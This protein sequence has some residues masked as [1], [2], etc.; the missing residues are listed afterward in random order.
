[1]S[2]LARQDRFTTAETAQ[3][4]NTKKTEEQN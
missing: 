2:G 1:Q 3:K 4:H